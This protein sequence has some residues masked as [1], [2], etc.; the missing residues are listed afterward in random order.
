MASILHK[1]ATG[2]LV[3]KP[4]RAAAHARAPARARAQAA[5]VR[6]T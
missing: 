6:S 4:S 3:A 2:Q 1:Y 5:K